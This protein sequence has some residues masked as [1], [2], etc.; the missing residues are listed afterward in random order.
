MKLGGKII[1]YSRS[2]SLAQERRQR[3]E[4]VTKLQKERNAKPNPTRPDER[5]VTKAGLAENGKRGN[6]VP[7]Y[8]SS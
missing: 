7:P 3:R 8:S 5:Q 2:S 4:V 1:T 6:S